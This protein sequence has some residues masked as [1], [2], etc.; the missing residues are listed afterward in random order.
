MP[1]LAI[2]LAVFLL[3]ACA[4]K[5]IYNVNSHPVPFNAQRLSL[6]QI[7]TLIVNA[8]QNRGWKVTRVAAGKLTAAQDMPKY[9][10]E[11]E[12][13]YDQKSYTIRHLH[14]RGMK[15]QGDLIHPHYNFWIRNLEADIETWLSN[16][17]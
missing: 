13:L 10:A 8:G 12:I 17:S 15:E 6:G 14:S 5:P 4:Q 2:V 3:G 1:R 16:A 9:G 7:E 11:V